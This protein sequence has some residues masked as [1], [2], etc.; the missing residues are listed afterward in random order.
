M[1]LVSA[2]DFI[3]RREWVVAHTIQ[4]LLRYDR[5]L[6]HHTKCTERSQYEKLDSESHLEIP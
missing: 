2:S 5:E 6:V 4:K 1:T 3:G